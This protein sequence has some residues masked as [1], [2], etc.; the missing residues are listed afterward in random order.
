MPAGDFVLRVT[1]SL[2]RLHH[3]VRG[4]AAGAVDDIVVVAREVAALG[5]STLMMRAPKSA[6]TP[7]ANRRGDGLFHRDDREHR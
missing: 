5:F 7:G 2:P 6:S 1:D 3:E 4:Q